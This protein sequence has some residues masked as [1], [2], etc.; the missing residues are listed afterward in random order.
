MLKLETRMAVEPD[1]TRTGRA[2]RIFREEMGVPLRTVARRMRVSVAYVSYLE[3]GKRRWT[4][5]IMSRYQRALRGR[6]KR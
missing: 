2:A 3:T 6:G 4:P 1:H 5:G